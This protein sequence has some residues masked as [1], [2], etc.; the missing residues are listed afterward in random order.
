MRER[1]MVCGAVAQTVALLWIP[2]CKAL[3]ADGCWHVYLDLG[4]NVGLQVRKLYELQQFKNASIQHV[5]HK[6][7]GQDQLERRQHVCAIGFEPNPRHHA[8]LKAIQSRYNEL[9]WRTRFELVAVGVANSEAKFFFDNSTG[10]YGG[11][12]NHEWGASTVLIPFIH[13]TGRASTVTRTIDLPAWVQREILER[14]LPL[15]HP[16]G[17]P[18]IVV[19]L[20]IEGGEF[21]V[22]PRLLQSGVL[23]RLTQLHA[24]IHV[25][26]KRCNLRCR[27][28]LE[29]APG[30]AEHPRL[31]EEIKRNLTVLGSR[32]GVKFSREN[33]ESYTKAVVPLPPLMS[34]EVVEHAES[35]Q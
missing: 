26:V 17:D 27:Q 24:E 6:Y 28:I 1:T 32:C 23:C 20:D 33:D 12:N 29:Q 7:F 25:D 34:S 18:H 8:S 13:G 2:A 14:R 15:T 10:K 16:A 3:A 35:M 21:A 22:L 31:F 5:F 9:G 4:S 11:Q 30:A 19:K